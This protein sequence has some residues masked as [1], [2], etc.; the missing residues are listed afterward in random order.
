MTMHKEATAVSAVFCK[1]G[2]ES[3]TSHIESMPTTVAK[4][5]T[6]ADEKMSAGRKEANKKSFSKS[7]AIFPKSVS[8]IAYSC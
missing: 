5:A 7:P 4:V 1:A 6:K 8:I 3:T 2:K